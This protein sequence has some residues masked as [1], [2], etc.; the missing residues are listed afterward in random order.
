VASDLG[1]R[2]AGGSPPVVVVVFDALPTA[3]LLD[4]RGGIDRRV[5]P[6]MA[7]LAGDATWYRRNTTVSGWTLES[8]GAL[9]TGTLPASPARRALGGDDRRNLFTLLG[10]SY[11]VHAY[12][13]VTRLCPVRLCPLAA[14]CE[15]PRPCGGTGPA[16][17]SA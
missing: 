15:T 5:A 2:R 1:A 16:A 9:L 6:N 8:L 12:E 11:E 14:C 4:G 17:R 13:P 7:A 10:G 3:S